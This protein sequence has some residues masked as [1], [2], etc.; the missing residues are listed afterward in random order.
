MTL[1]NTE[2]SQKRQQVGKHLEKPSGGPLRVSLVP[3]WG[4]L[5][6]GG[7]DARAAGCHGLRVNVQQAKV[8][9]EGVCHRGR[10]LLPLEE[11]RAQLVGQLGHAG[12]PQVPRWPCSGRGLCGPLPHPTPFTSA[13]P[14]SPLSVP[15]FT[16]PFLEDRH[17]TDIIRETGFTSR[18]GRL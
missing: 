17:Y 5:T 4:A 16:E 13:H 9:E 15:G 1:L 18:P 14:K 12:P 8:L 10:Q 2:R 11:G 3:G 6:D 7:N